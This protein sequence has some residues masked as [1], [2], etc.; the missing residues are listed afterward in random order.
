VSKTTSP[1]P[2]RPSGGSDRR[3]AIG[4]WIGAGLGVL[5]VAA[6]LVATLVSGGGDDAAAPTTT[7]QAG[8][9]APTG[10]EVTGTVVTPPGDYTA[11]CAELTRQTASAK[12]APGTPEQ[13]V[14]L[15]QMVD[16]SALAAVAPEGLRPSLEVLERT[17]GQ[18]V[19]LF[20]QLD[21]FSELTNADF[22]AGFL[23]AARQLTQAT[24]ENCT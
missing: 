3:Q 9:V 6:V 7:S 8:P 1:G 4:I 16:F 2:D 17:S 15:A 10:I 21:D 5:V 22:P 14:E 13:L 12:A 20:E 23:D 24:E 18:V 19:A 11:F